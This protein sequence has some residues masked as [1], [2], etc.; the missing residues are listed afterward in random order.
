MTQY[1]RNFATLLVFFLAID[2]TTSD[3]D[4]SLEL[5]AT[6]LNSFLEKEENYQSDGSDDSV[7]TI[8][9]KFD[10]IGMTTREY[11]LTDEERMIKKLINKQ[12]KWENSKYVSRTGLILWIWIFF[13][14]TL[15]TYLGT[16]L[17]HNRKRPLPRLEIL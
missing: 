11:T 3:L 2:D 15:I 12:N 14:L 4:S 16:P 9:V 1:Q 10:P 6:N 8:K 13:D 5:R 17:R 7:G